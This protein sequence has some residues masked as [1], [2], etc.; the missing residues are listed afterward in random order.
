M[1]SFIVMLVSAFGIGALHALEPGHGKSIMG[2]YLVLSRGKPVHAVAL[3]LTSAA[4]HTLVIVV[5][6]L[7]AHGVMGAAAEQGSVP[8]QTVETWLKIVSGVLITGI[9]LMMAFR[10]MPKCSCRHRHYTPDGGEIVEWPTLIL[11]G[12][13]NGLI[14]CP[15]ALAVLLMSISTGAVF[16]GL[17]LVLAFGIGGA[18]SL[19][20]VGLVFLKL[21]HTAG[22]FMSGTAWSRLANVSGLLIAAIGFFT[23]YGGIQTLV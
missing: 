11:L 12:L 20:A 21:S 3:G 22:R 15:S 23:C 16:S 13:T 6:S 10:R 9:G 17:V 18:V 5:M 8:Q 2:T 1:M 4:T 19:I 7:A 14:P